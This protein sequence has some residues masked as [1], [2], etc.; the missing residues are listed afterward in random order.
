MRRDTH[1]LALRSHYAKWSSPEGHV[2]PVCVGGTVYQ[3]SAAA[4]RCRSRR[5][6]AILRS[7]IL[8]AVVDLD[9]DLDELHLE[10]SCR[11]AVVP[12]LYTGLVAKTPICVGPMHAPKCCQND[13]L[14]QNAHRESSLARLPQHARLVEPR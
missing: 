9:H 2:V 14:W 7:E 8:T 13:G 11:D 6:A 4:L 5:L 10:K 1:A 3:I 12:F